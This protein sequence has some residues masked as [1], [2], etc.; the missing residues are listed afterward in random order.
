M[1]HGHTAEHNAQNLK[2]GCYAAC[3]HKA[4]AITARPYVRAKH[5]VGNRLDIDADKGSTMFARPNPTP[6][7]L[8]TASRGGLAIPAVR[9]QRLDAWRDYAYRTIITSDGVRLAVRDYGSAGAANHTVVL[10]HGL[11]LTKSSWALQI[12]ELRLRWGNSLRIITY[13][14]RGHGGSTGA[15]MQT[16]QIDRLAA[17]LADVLTALRVRGPLTLA[18]HSM[19]GMTALAYLGH[20]TCDRPV[21]PQGLVLVATAAG[22]LAERGL[23]RLLGTPMTGVL[24]GLVDRIPRRAADQAIEGLTRPIRDGLVRYSGHGIAD[25][26]ASA[27]HTISLTTAAGFLPSLKR[28]DQYHTLKSIGAKT[29]VISGGADMTTPATHARDLAATI[30][31]AT[32]LH[33]PTAGHMLLQEESGLVTNAID[34][35]MGLPR[36]PVQAVSARVSGNTSGIRQLTAAVS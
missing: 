10:L 3:A 26:T 34:S 20:P 24:F 16:Y 23:G 18:G 19:G 14:H 1:S 21:E 31:G 11:C 32:H 17:D 30:P 35:V 12:R 27:I 28:Y 36:P 15:K 22:R 4:D 6:T 9:P 8:P 25:A 5:G 13:D 2:I 7:S 33:R 29:I